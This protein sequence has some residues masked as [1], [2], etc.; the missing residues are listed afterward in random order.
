[1]GE[2][3]K[4]TRKGSKKMALSLRLQVFLDWKL[5]VLIASLLVEFLK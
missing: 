4:T 5:V 1:M 3:V 2:T